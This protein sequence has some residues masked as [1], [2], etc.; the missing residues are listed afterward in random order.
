M[1][2]QLVACLM[3]LLLDVLC[4]I[5]RMLFGLRALAQLLH[6]SIK[7]LPPKS[8]LR[9]DETMKA[10]VDTPVDVHPRITW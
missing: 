1:S 8:S 3:S 4:L 7:A 2:C 5:R 6:I 9:L 10:R